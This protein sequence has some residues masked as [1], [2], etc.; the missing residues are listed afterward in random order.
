MDCRVM[1]KTGHSHIHARI[2]IPQRTS[3][4]RKRTFRATKKLGSPKDISK[5]E[6]FQIT[7]VDCAVKKK[8]GH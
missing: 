4:P 7:K 2:P 6:N 1:G 8:T 5:E 3:L